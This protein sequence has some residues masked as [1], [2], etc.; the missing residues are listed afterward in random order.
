MGILVAAVRPCVWTP[1]LVER[2][3]VLGA[4]LAVAPLLIA[5]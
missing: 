5:T 3:A 1:D 2:T 4:A